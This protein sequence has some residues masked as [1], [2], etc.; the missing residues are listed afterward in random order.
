MILE[1]TCLQFRDNCFCIKLRKFSWLKRKR[2]H[3]LHQ[4]ITRLF[5]S[6]KLYDYFCNKI[7][8]L[9]KNYVI[10]FFLENVRII[11]YLTCILILCNNSFFNYFLSSFNVDMFFSSAV[12]TDKNQII[13]IFRLSEDADPNLLVMFSFLFFFQCRYDFLFNFRN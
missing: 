7:L 4:I 13:I 11:H 10:K 6:K 8:F 2:L 5:C 3:F 9:Y 12:V 1:N